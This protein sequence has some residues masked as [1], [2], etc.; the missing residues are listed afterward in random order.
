MRICLAQYAPLEV[1]VRQWSFLGFT[2]E[3]LKQLSVVTEKGRHAVVIMDDAGWHTNDIAEPFDN[4][5][6]IKLPP[7]SP[8]LNPIEQVW[9]WLRQH[10]LANQSFA[11]YEDIVSKVC[12]AWN[13]FLECSARVRQM[14]SRS[15]IDLTS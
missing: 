10:S 2:V 12:R 13:S 8:E 7:Y 3:H 9:S 11:D 1:L 15:W 6:I 4:V 14:C 5:S